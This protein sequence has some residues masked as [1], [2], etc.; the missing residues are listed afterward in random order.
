MSSF[1]ESSVVSPDYE[2]GSIVNLMSSLAAG[3]VSKSPY[4]R[5]DMIDE[6]KLSESENVILL[7]LDGIGYEYLREKGKDTVLYDYLKERMTSVFPSSTASA[8]PTFYTGLAPQQHA[9]TGWYTFLRE[10]GVVTTILPFK[11]R[12]GESSLRESGVDISSVLSSRSV[13]D[14]IERKSIDVILEKLKDSA[15]N[16]FYAESSERMGYFSLG[17]LFSLI[18]RLIKS[19]DEKRYIKAYWNGF[20]KAAHEEGVNGIPASKEFLDLSLQLREF[21]EDIKDTDTALIIT[22]DHGF[23]DSEEE[24]SVRLKDHPQLQDCLTLPLCGDHRT[25]FCYV[26]PSKTD[27][28][29]EYWE[30]NL[31]DFCYMYRSEKLIEE[32]YFGLFEPDPQLYHRIG[33][34]TL[35]M[36]DNYVFHDALINED[37]HFEIGNHGGVSEKEMYVP[38]SMIELGRD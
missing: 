8:V 31:S 15:F 22:S 14:N 7:V 30:E 29:E 6:R 28:F 10:L 21:V 3:L 23:I 24:K 20:D 26:H 36:K 12:F 11:P 2:E 9:V 25:V 34:Y 4:N 27:E 33:D 32:N 16:S 37:E 13:M 18:E 19:G 5:I 1:D 17:E 35:I 38:L